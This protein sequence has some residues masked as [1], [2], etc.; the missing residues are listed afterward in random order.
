MINLSFLTAKLIK[1]LDN[2]N[3]EGGK[4]RQDNRKQL[5]FQYNLNSKR[6]Q[7]F[8]WSMTITICFLI[9]LSYHQTINRLQSA[10]LTDQEKAK[11]SQSYTCQCTMY[12]SNSKI[13]IQVKR[14]SHGQ[15]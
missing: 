2:Y 4:Y 11:A 7:R 8:C 1:G 3:R 12:N 14:L 13:E 15:L 6:Y 9:P 5:M 10:V